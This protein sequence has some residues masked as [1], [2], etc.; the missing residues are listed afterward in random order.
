[1]K[2]EENLDFPTGMRFSLSTV[3]IGRFGE[4]HQSGC[5]WLNVIESIRLA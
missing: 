5:L 1:M 2:C 4:L 3:Y